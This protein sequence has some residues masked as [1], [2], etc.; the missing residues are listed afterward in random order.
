MS[1]GDHWD[2]P[3]RCGRCGQERG[4]HDDGECSAVTRIYREPAKVNIDKRN[5][6]ELRMQDV[7]LKVMSYMQGGNISR[8]EYQ[9]VM[10]ELRD[11]KVALVNK[12]YGCATGLHASNCTCEPD[13]AGKP[14][15]CIKKHA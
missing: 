7:V 15:S 2:E 3:A 5:A 14:Y 13:H 8:L 6:L 9:E 10:G 1:H 4:T 11:I 12:Q